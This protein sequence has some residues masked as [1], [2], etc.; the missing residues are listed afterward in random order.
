MSIRRENR[1][2]ASSLRQSF[3]GAGQPSRRSRSSAQ[4]AGE[5]LFGRAG[6]EHPQAVATSPAASRRRPALPT[7]MARSPPSRRTVTGLLASPSRTQ[8]RPDRRGAGPAGLG[9][10]HPRSHTRMRTEPSASAWMNSTFTRLGNSG[11]R[12]MAA[13]TPAR[14]NVRRIVDQDD[15]MGIAH[16]DERE[17]IAAPQRPPETASTTPS[18]AV[19]EPAAADRC[20]ALRSGPGPCPPGPCPSASRRGVIGPASV[21]TVNSG[22]ATSARWPPGSARRC[23]CRCRTS[24]IRCRRG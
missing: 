19:C 8:P 4:L 2:S 18:A 12:S 7:S 3:A 21:S 6:H 14:S 9:L 22:S 1:T 15:T 11:C 20:W 13:P 23:G 24:P 5:D 10:P 17:A 16:V